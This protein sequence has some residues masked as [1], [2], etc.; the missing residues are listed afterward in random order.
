MEKDKAKYDGILCFLLAVIVVLIL[1]IGGG[2]YYFLVLDNGEEISENKTEQVLDK[3]ESKLEANLDINDELVKKLYSFIPTVSFYDLLPTAYQTTKVTFNDLPNQVK[4]INVFNHIDFN[5]E[6]VEFIYGEKDKIQPETWFKFSEEIMNEKTKEFYGDNAVIKNEHFDINWGRSCRYENG[7]YVHSSGG[8]GSILEPISYMTKVEKDSNNIYIYDKFI[9]VKD[10]EKNNVYGES[11]YILDTT[12]DASNIID[13]YKND[14][15]WALKLDEFNQ[16]FIEKYKNKMK[17]Y[18]H[19]F[20]KNENGEYYWYSTEPVNVG[21]TNNKTTKE[22]SQTELKELETYIINNELEYFLIEDYTD[23][24]EARLDEGI[25]YPYITQNGKSLTNN[26][27]LEY[28]GDINDGGDTYKI[29]KSKVEEFLK[30]NTG[31]TLDEFKNGK[32]LGKNSRIQYSEKDNL[33]YMSTA[34]ALDTISGKLVSAEK[35]GNKYVL[36]YEKSVLTLNKVENRYLVVSHT[37][38]K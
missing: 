19:T 11:L 1:V 6:K 16:F 24:R 37:L 18:K 12:N 20:K 36:N 32:D 9:V 38:K 13:E 15:V 17:E 26:E 2:A 14:D 7:I 10:A 5:N 34:G 27:E 33:Y 30:N 22:L 3:N 23:V 28:Y 4:L 35:D 31:Y 8:G 21:T 29:A 25:L